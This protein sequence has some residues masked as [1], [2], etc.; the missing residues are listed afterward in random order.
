MLQ[1]ADTFYERMTTNIPDDVFLSL[2]RNASDL[3]LY[4]EVSDRIPIDGSYESGNTGSGYYV[5]PDFEVNNRHLQDSIYKGI[6]E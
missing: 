5:I 4:R 3:R 2:A 1:F 6:H